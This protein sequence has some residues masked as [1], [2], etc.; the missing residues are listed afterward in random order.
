MGDGRYGWE[1]ARR[2]GEVSSKARHVEARRLDNAAHRKRL[3][4]VDAVL[5]DRL[6]DVQSRICET[7]AISRAGSCPRRFRGVSSQAQPQIHFSTCCGLTKEASRTYSDRQGS[8]NAFQLFTLSLTRTLLVSS[9]MTAHLLGLSK[10][11]LHSR[12]LHNHTLHNRILHS[13]TENKAN[14]IAGN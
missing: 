8:N 14:T 5:V 9:G 11:I 1:M 2:K 13:R 6:G 4:V 12:I 7:A 3:I 10:H